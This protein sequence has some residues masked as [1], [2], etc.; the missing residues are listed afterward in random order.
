MIVTYRGGF[1]LVRLKVCDSFILSYFPL[2]VRKNLK[3]S[4]V[5]IFYKITKCFHHAK[6]S[7]AVT[8]ISLELRNFKPHYLDRRKISHDVCLMYRKQ[9]H[10]K[11]MIL[12]RVSEVIA[13]I[14]N[15]VSEVIA[16]ILN[17]VSEVIAL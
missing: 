1:I 15:R 3:V 9:H 6:M 16:L 10:V 5:P 12:N 14:L 7:L 13:L 17:R 8:A 2:N 4:K 11:F